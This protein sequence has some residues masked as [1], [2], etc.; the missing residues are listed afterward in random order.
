MTVARMQPT[1]ALRNPREIPVYA[2]CLVLNVILA[3]VLVGL[4][5]LM[6]V[7][8]PVHAVA[9]I[10]TPLR[11]A[12]AAILLAAFVVGIS[13]VLGRQLLRASSRGSSV[14][15][16]NQ[17]PEIDAILRDAAIRLSFGR[18]RPPEIYVENGNGVLNA[19]AASTFAHDY[20]VVNSGL[21]ANTLE[22]NQRALRFIVGH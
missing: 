14:L 6:L 2:L 7:P 22:Q 18:G 19:F 10:A 16:S 15:A 21:F 3:V 8:T 1:P 11:L 20:V 4:A 13:I 17:F 5:I 9:L 12:I